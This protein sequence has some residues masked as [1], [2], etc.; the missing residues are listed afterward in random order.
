MTVRLPHK[1]GIIIST[2]LGKHLL[3]VALVLQ[4]SFSFAV[5]CK[6]IILHFLKLKLVEHYLLEYRERGEESN[7]N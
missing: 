6:E 4:N 2:V 3:H 5:Y 7:Q 1:S